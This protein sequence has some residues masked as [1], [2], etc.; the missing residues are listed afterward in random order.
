MRRHHRTAVTFQRPGVDLI[1][2]FAP[3][4]TDNTLK[5]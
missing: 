4:F 2:R 5:G 1:S 3:K